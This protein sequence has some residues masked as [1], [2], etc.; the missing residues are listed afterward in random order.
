MVEFDVCQLV[1][2][3]KKCMTLRCCLNLSRKACF[4]CPMSDSAGVFEVLSHRPHV[5]KIFGWGTS[6]RLLREVN[7]SCVFTINGRDKKPSEMK[8]QVSHSLELPFL[9][10]DAVGNTRSMNKELLQ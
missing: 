7:L 8:G 1:S 5:N 3:K 9:I 6:N 2:L 10:V 4:V